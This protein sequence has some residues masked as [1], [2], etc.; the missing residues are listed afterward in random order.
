MVTI[1]DR[2]A[3]EPLRAGL[4]GTGWTTSR[5]TGVNRACS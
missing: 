5:A 2:L 1:I 4:R 3:L